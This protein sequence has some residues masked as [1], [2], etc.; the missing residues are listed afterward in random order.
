MHGNAQS[1]GRVEDT[2]A[3]H[4]DAHSALVRAVANLAHCAHG[5]HRSARHIVGL[6]DGDR[7][8]WA[9][10]TD[11]PGGWRGVPLPRTAIRRSV[12]MARI[13]QPLNQAI[14]ESS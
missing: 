2:G 13:R 4:V 5:V 11:S 12:G 1:R 3:I 14:M 6:L 7:A 10:C 9:R 8:R